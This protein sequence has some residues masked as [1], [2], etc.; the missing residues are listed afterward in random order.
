MQKEHKSNK[1][2][3]DIIGGFKIFLISVFVVYFAI[4]IINAIPNIN[5]PIKTDSAWLVSFI[6]GTFITFISYTQGKMQNYFSKSKN[7]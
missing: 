1:I 5:F 7:K 4:A 3:Q 6:V 2:I